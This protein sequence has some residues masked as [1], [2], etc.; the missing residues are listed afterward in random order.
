MSVDKRQDRAGGAETRHATDGQE[1]PACDDPFA[2]R[3]S[4]FSYI[5][6]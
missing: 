2:T 6:S 5:I 1:R 4:L 3:L